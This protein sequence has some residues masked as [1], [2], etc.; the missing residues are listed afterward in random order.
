MIAAPRRMP[1]RRRWTI[2][3]IAVAVASPFF[4]MG[5]IGGHMLYLSAGLAVLLLARIAVPSRPDAPLA[6]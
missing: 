2:F 6:A 4:W 3:V 5:F 1:D